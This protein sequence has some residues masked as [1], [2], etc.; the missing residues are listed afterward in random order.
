M[1]MPKIEVGL[2][3]IMRSCNSIY[4]L[5]SVQRQRFRLC[6]RLRPIVPAPKRPASG[7]EHLLDSG[8]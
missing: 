2:M 4:I 5:M 1:M 6:K 8:G 7:G 3:K